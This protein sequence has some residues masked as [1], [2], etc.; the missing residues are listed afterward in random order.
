M[1]IRK[2]SKKLTVRFAKRLKIEMQQAII[3]SD[4]G[5]HGK[6]RWL[7]EA[8]IIF[9]N[10]ANYVELVEHGININQADL[11]EVEA[12]YLDEEMLIK[13]KNALT[14]VRVKYPLFEGV[15]SAFIRAC[16]IYK[17]MLRK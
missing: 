7:A 6:S 15:Q 14:N 2:K 16:V 11:S 17:L 8:I 3:N 10:Q 4:Y 13:V 9:L 1:Q 5:L 12:F